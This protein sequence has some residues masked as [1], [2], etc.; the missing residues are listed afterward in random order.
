MLSLSYRQ[1]LIVAL[2]LMFGTFIQSVIA[3]TDG[4][5]T[6]ELG[7]TAYN[8]VGNGG[9]FYVALFMLTRGLADGAQITIARR[10]GEQ[11]FEKVGVVLFNAQI[12][13]LLLSFLIFLFFLFFAGPIIHSIAKSP[14]IGEAMTEFLRYRSWGIIFASLQVTMVALF[15]GLGKTKIIIASTIILAGFNILLDYGL[16]FGR[17]GLPEMGM[18]GAAI[19]SSVSEMITFFFLLIYAI[20]AKHLKE[21]NLKLRQKINRAELL[22]LVRMSIP[23]MLQGL[24][25][26][27]TWLVF[28]SMIEHMGPVDLEISHNIRYM[29]FIAFVPIFGYAAAT[30]TYVSNLVG[31]NELK[32]IPRV[33]F[34]IAVLSLISI[35]VLFHGAILYPETLIEIVERNPHADPIVI[36]KSA[37]TLRF[38]S[39]SIILFAVVIV[40]FHSVAALGKTYLS[41]LFEAISICIYMA[42]CYLFIEVWQWDVVKIWWVEY[43]YFGTLGLI[44]S[45]FL[46]YYY[47]RVSVL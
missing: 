19:A 11:A 35:L 22:A 16:I 41:F 10:Y 28:F 8:A 30:R 46:L 45:V 15:I 29:Y 7:S 3:I 37:E 42:A 36:Q 47:R 32:E 27:S 39:G 6:S 23:L 31:R 5:F 21:F 20:K 18:K 40:P 12:V 38:V 13:Q 17:L 24:I 14:N 34:K 33:Q 1:I 26:L 25:A 43:V 4:A 9:M 44:S 2:P